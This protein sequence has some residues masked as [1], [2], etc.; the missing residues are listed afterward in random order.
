MG[1]KVFI[2]YKYG[3]TNV[4]PLK[5]LRKL[6]LKRHKPKLE[7]SVIIILDGGNH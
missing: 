7:I 6:T 2:S 4:A 5:G 3:D 1:K